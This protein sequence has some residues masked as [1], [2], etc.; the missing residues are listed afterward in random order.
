[1]MHFLITGYTIYFNK[2]NK[3][4]GHLF[5]GRF[6]AVLIE[7]VSYAKELS[8][9]IHLNPVRAG[10]VDRPGQY[11]WSTFEYYCRAAVPEQWVETSV[12]LRLFGDQLKE[13]KKAH[14]EFVTSGI[15]MDTPASIKNSL[16]TGILGSEDF[17]ARIKKDYLEL[18]L[19]KIDREKPQLRQ[20]K[21]KPDLPRILSMSEK[22]LG[23][24]NRWVVPI[25]ILI[26][27][28]H[29]DIKLGELAEFFSL[30]VSG[31][32]NAYSRAE[33]AI[34]GNPPLARAVHEIKL[35]IEKKR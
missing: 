11:P 33:T 21:D 28:A 31:V 2:K 16:K 12:V 20:L 4:H 3:R 10:I 13:S 9:Y 5:Q 30:S 1:M 22:V 35:A 23:P 19:G 25:A 29:M 8:R 17:V 6:R 15:G 26:S 32:S 34:A 7:A 24:C 27:Y 14:A 18:E